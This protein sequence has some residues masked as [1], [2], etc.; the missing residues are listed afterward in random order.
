MRIIVTLILLAFLTGCA[1][2]GSIRAIKEASPMRWFPGL[3]R[4][5]P[6]AWIIYQRGPTL[7]RY[8]RNLNWLTYRGMHW[9]GTT[10][11]S[12]GPDWQNWPVKSRRNW[13]PDVTGHS[14][15]VLRFWS[16]L[17][18]RTPGWVGSE[19][20]PCCSMT[21]RGHGFF[22][23]RSTPTFR[24]RLTPRK[25]R[26]IAAPVRPAWIFARLR[27]LWRLGCLMLGNVSHT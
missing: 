24:S 17:W 1:A 21:K 27:R 22:W 10:T 19:R 4:S 8:C 2:P 15:T 9:V 13:V 18:Q 11:N 6:P 16:A 7:S 25:R 14:S 23:E 5:S 3:A 20:T 26:S 12:C